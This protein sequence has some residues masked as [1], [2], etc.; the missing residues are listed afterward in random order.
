MW[1]A[2][3]H[4]NTLENKRATRN[5]NKR[6]YMINLVHIFAKLVTKLLANR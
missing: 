2:P 1:T 3:R 5:D 6:P 4:T